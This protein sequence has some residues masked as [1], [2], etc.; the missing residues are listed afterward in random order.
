MQRI[1]ARDRQVGKIL[2]TLEE[3]CD[4]FRLTEPK[5]PS[6]ILQKR[7]DSYKRIIEFI[8]QIYNEFLQ[9]HRPSLELARCQFYLAKLFLSCPYSF[10]LTYPQEGRL[11]K[12]FNHFLI[13]M[14]H[15]KQIEFANI[16]SLFITII[17]LEICEWYKNPGA[18]FVLD[19]LKENEKR[20]FQAFLTHIKN[21]Q[22][23]IVTDDAKLIFNK[24]SITINEPY[25]YQRFFKLKP[26]L[27]LGSVGMALL[28]SRWIYSRL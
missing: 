3:D 25:N 23:D 18:S 14:Q 16:R 10:K 15:T 8:I 21:E 26:L 20:I 2:D 27:F 24:M 4:S 7:I 22:S 17:F 5:H 1:A 9:E 13:S 6:F 11:Q 28:L 12:S 19:G